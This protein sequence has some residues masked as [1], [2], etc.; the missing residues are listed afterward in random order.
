MI[1]PLLHIASRLRYDTVNRHLASTHLNLNRRVWSGLLVGAS[2]LL[3]EGCALEKPEQEQRIGE[4][5][6]F[7]FRPSENRMEGVIVGA[8][9]GSAEPAAADYASFISE[10]T[11]ASPLPTIHA[12]VLDYGRIESIP[13]RNHWKGIVIGA[14]HG[15][16]DEHTAELVKEVSL[17]TGLAAVIATGFTPTECRG[18]RINVNR[19]T[20]SR[21]PLGEIEIHSKRADEVYRSFKEA[22]WEVAQNEPTV[23]IDIHQNGRQKDIEVATVG[24]SKEQATLIKR[25]YRQIRDRVIGAAPGIA[26]VDLLVEPRD[27]IEIGAWAAKTDGILSVAKKSLHFELPLYDTL[28]TSKA[29]AAYT[30]IL[31]NLFSLTAPALSNG[32][33]ETFSKNP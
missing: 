27:S 24:I 3:W 6:R 19:P 12:R 20:E 9:H 7:H 21:Y 33:Q 23:Y 4:L 8:P 26:S 17:R 10:H 29:R 28:R 1:P 25:A 15:T 32:G 22:V 2:L 13:S 11:G 14:P 5:G 31:A 16:F 18:W 30:T